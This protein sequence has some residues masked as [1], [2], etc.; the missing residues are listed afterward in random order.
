VILVDSDLAR[1]EH[2][3]ILEMDLGFGFNPNLLN[4]MPGLGSFMLA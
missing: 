4:A 3:K 1:E 2:K